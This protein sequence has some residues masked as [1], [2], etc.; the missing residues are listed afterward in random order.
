VPQR[1]RLRATRRPSRAKAQGQIVPALL[2][3]GRIAAAHGL[4]GL[5]KLQTFTADPMGIG[6][7]GPLSDAAGKRV[8]KLTALNPVKGGVVASIDGVADRTAAEKLRGVELYMPRDRLPPAGE[9]E[10]YHADLVGL[11]A[12]LADGRPFG[13]VRA[14]ENYGAG[15]LLAIEGVDGRPVSLP[16]TDRVVP[17]VD[18]A[19]GRIVVEPPEGLLEEVKVEEREG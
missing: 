9:G 12:E 3:V 2:L 4:R 1:R 19:G 17:V 6:G 15:D 11:T 13:R 8:F 16:F 14:V 5:V 18:L 7:Y 10:Y